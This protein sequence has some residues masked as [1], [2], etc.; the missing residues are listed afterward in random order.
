MQWR[1][2]RASG[3][4]VALKSMPMMATRTLTVTSRPMPPR[5]TKTPMPRSAQR[6]AGEPAAGATSTCAAAVPPGRGAAPGPSGV[7]EEGAGA[8]QLGQ[9]VPRH[10]SRG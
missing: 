9:W 8:L 6:P 3:R 4:P 2:S 5:S 10:P 7:A 1:T